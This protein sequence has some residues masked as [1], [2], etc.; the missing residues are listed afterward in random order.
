MRT[1]TLAVA[2]AGVSAAVFAASGI[3]YALTAESTPASVAVQQAAQPVQQAAPA[4]PAVQQGAQPVQQAAPATAVEGGGGE[5][6]ERHEGRDREDGGRGHGHRGYGHREEGRIHFNDRTYS[7]SSE[8]CIT[9]ISGLGASSFSVFNDSWKTV[10]VFRGFTCD[11]GAP[12]AIVGPHGETNGVVTRT[13]H[14]GVFGDDGVVGS[15]RV[16]RDYDEW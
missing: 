5:N 15:F 4:P 10:E 1:R 6:G 8:G 7:A 9:A 16:I 3:T 2:A 12:V 13:V 14:G 11:N